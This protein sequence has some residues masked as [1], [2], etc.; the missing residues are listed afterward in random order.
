MD[1]ILSQI[2]WKPKGFKIGE[3]SLGF[4]GVLVGLKIGNEIN[5]SFSVT[6]AKNSSQKQIIS[7][8]E[9]HSKCG[10]SILP[11]DGDIIVGIAVATRIGEF[12]LNKIEVF[13]IH[14]GTMVVLNPGVWH[15]V[16]FLYRCQSASI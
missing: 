5:L 6:K 11:L 4:Y 8:M 1:R 13:L 2:C 15:G 14:R 3:G 7:L 16:L 10:E 9:Y 12:T